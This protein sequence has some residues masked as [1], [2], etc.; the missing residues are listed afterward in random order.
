[1]AF[2]RAA[3]GTEVSQPWGSLYWVTALFY[4]LG[5]RPRFPS[6]WSEVFLSLLCKIWSHQQMWSNSVHAQ[7][8]GL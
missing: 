7:A 6:P 4:G 1:M 3:V 8:L 5:L 2:N